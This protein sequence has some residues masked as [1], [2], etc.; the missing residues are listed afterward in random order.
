MS[1][2]SYWTDILLRAAANGITEAPS[3]AYT[4]RARINY[5]L[6]QLTGIQYITEMRGLP[7]LTLLKREMARWKD[8]PATQKYCIT[9]LRRIYGRAS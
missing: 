7:I 4:E 8:Y 5:Q 3:E 9:E 1:W 2:E 6:E